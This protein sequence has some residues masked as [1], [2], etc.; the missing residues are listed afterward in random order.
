MVIAAEAIL[1]IK[2]EALGWTPVGLSVKR[3]Q[4]GGYSENG[5]HS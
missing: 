4:A 5:R 1:K 2:T 3:N